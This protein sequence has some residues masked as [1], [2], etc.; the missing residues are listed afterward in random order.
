[1]LKA[2]QRQFIFGIGMMVKLTI[3]LIPELGLCNGSRGV[4]RE[5]IYPQGGYDRKQSPVIM[6]EFADYKGPRYSESLPKTWIPIVAVQR[7]CECKRCFRIGFPLQVTKADTVH[8]LQ[9]AT[10]GE[11]HAIRRLLIKWS[12]A[13]EARWPNILYVAISR[14]KEIRD[15]AFDF[16]MTTD[17]MRS[18]GTSS[19]WMEQDREVQRI[20]AKAM[21]RRAH[22]AQHYQGTNTHFASQVKQLCA[23]ASH[24]ALQNTN[25]SIQIEVQ[26]CVAQ[27]LESIT[28]WES[29]MDTS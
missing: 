6:V 4:I 7:Q 23:I 21:Q 17:A 10:C 1:M 27:W 29:Q 9:G 16:S 8:S 26:S 3:N 28:D 15:I 5:I 19:S 20:H 22:M 2:I 12:K 18:I 11:N 13:D 24:K 25:T 14:A